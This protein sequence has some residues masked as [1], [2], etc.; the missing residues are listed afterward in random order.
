[1]FR[2]RPHRL[3]AVDVVPNVLHVETRVQCLEWI[4]LRMPI[5][6]LVVHPGERDELRVDLPISKWSIFV[7]ALRAKLAFVTAFAAALVAIGLLSQGGGLREMVPTW[8]GVLLASL[9]LFLFSLFSQSLVKAS[10]ERAQELAELAGLSAAVRLEIDVAFGLLTTDQAVSE[11]KRRDRKRSASQGV[12][13][14]VAQLFSS[15]W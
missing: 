12:D 8:S 7:A 2:Q 5:S 11:L 14:R 1:M 10:Y 9:P 4:P 6:Q 13:T 3:A 15:T